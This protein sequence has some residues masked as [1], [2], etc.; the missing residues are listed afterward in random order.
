M[1]QP[2]GELTLADHIFQAVLNLLSKEVADYGRHLSQYFNLFLVY[3][4]LGPPE[5][6]HLLLLNVLAT[7][8]A[9]GESPGPSI[10]YRY[11]ELGKLSQV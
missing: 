3:A 4:S 6:A 1:L 5:K 2:V 7:I 10:K 8:V 11:A 9:L